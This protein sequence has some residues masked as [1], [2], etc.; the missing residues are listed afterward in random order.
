MNEARLCH[1]IEK[2]IE[3]RRRSTRDMWRA[4]YHAYRVVGQNIDGATKDLA[5]LAGVT[6]EA[7]QK[8]ARAYRMF[9]ELCVVNYADAKAFRRILSPSHFSTMHEK[10]Q[11]HEIPLPAAESYLA[12]MVANKADDKP[13]SVAAL[14]REIQAHYDMLGERPVITWVSQREHVRSA[15]IRWLDYKDMPPDV[16]G[17]I[18]KLL[19]ELEAS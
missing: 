5:D 8:W 17:L 2:A 11:K 13:H 19:R 9:A 1:D 3:Y 10:R 18:E 12:Q 4:A 16:Y 14:E 7:V 15:V 6:V